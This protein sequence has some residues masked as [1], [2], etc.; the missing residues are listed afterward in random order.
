[1]ARLPPTK[2][3]RRS[4]LI[5][6]GITDNGDG[7]FTITDGGHDF[8]Y[9]V[10]IGNKGTWSQAHVD[11]TAPVCEPHAGDNLF[12]E[13]FDGYAETQQ[14]FDPPGNFVF[15]TTNLDAADGWTG[16]SYAELGADGYGGIESTSGNAWFDTMNSPGSID[17]SH[18]GIV[19]P[20]GGQAQLSFSLGTQDLDY[21][22][23]HHETDPNAEIEFVWDGNVV[24]TYK[25]SDF[26]NAN[27]MQ[28]FN[29]LVDTGAAGDAHTLEIH[30]TTVDQ[31]NYTG[32]AL[33]SIQV[34]DWI[35][36]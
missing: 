1:M 6:H 18:G 19:D 10:Q 32:F 31:G 34:N 26:A 14:Y 4:T 3:I 5:D 35:V 28:E 17:M 25:A 16:A 23:I 13:N 7:T 12:T 33:D 20:T 21:L 24:A 9:F 29:I 22:G 15:A 2:T 30:D 11:V 8:D 36:C 27:V